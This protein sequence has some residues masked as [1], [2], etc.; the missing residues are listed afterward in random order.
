MTSWTLH[1]L[2]CIRKVNAYYMYLVMLYIDGHVS[3]FIQRN[4]SIFALIL[5]TIVDS[6]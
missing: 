5:A 3:G 4:E 2:E 1:V 6:S